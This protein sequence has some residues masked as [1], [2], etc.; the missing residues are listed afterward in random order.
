MVRGLVFV[1]MTLP[2]QLVISFLYGSL[3]TS[4]GRRFASV[5][6]VSIYIPTIISAVVTSLVFSLIYAYSG[7]LLNAVVGLFGIEDQAWIGDV[8]LALG[9]IAVPAI[10]M[11][12]G[13]M[14]LIMIAA[15]LD[16]PESLYEAAALE[17]ANWWQR[18]VY[19]TIP[20]M[21]NVLI[22]L[23]ITGFV[24]GIQQYE[25]PLVMTNGGP[26][27]STT[28]PNLFIFNHFRGDTYVGY[29]IAAALLLFVVLGTVSAG[30]F[31]VLNSEKLA[32]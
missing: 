22:Y 26:L 13:L 31:R 17:G 30:I 20:Q 21:K 7:G 29:S 4:V 25:L 5:L 2:A 24:A 12:L 6:K 16:I 14:S 15:M 8:D 3:V 32:D 9:A 18:T 27:N 23:L 28:L 11:G 10:W 19:I 1:L